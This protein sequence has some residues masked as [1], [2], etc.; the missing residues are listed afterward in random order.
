MF[1]RSMARAVIV[2]A[3]FVVVC[4]F[5][6]A[7][8]ATPV[9]PVT[10]PAQPTVPPSTPAP[11]VPVQPAPTPAQPAPR[12]QAT[13]PNVDPLS[14]RI[15]LGDGR[16]VW[17]PTRKQL[18]ASTDDFGAS[19][20]VDIS[21]TTKYLNSIAPYVR[22][23]PVS[24]RIAVLV[25]YAGNEITVKSSSVPVPVKIFPSRDGAVLD[26]DASAALIQ[27]TLQSSP[28]TTH[29]VL[30]TKDSP[31]RID[32]SKYSGIDSRIAHFVTHFN[33]GER[34]RTQTV[35]LAISLI[36]GKTVQSGEVLSV[37]QTVGERTA[38][39]GFGEGIVF[40]SGH[41]DKQLGGGMCQVATTLFNAVLLANLKVVERHQHIRTVPYV[42]PGEDATVYWGQKDFKFQNSSSVSIYISYKTTA[43]H[44]ICD[45]YGKGN[46]GVKVAI[47]DD[48]QKL[49]PRHYTAK[50]ERL[51]TVNGKTTVDYTARSAYEWTPALDYTF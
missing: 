11:T 30:V 28:Q 46:P 6:A 41:L 4:S 37:N 45:I 17:H 2:G 31:A 15:A 44:A 5:G 21:Q 48:Y 33:P 38:E 1:I 29:I 26:V 12:P 27:K 23:A 51:V 7:Q 13:Q 3:L 42:K 8:T 22:R 32:A 40:V 39:R 20:T 16:T 34:G 49:G 36:D 14:Q 24:A 50:L 9:A 19:F 47:V 43:T 18:G 10:P 25:K 35:R